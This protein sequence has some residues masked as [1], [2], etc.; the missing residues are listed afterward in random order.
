[1]QVLRAPQSV[2]QGF[3]WCR[4]VLNFEVGFFFESRIRAWSD[5]F[6]LLSWKK[7]RVCLMFWASSSM[8]A[9]R[10]GGIPPLGLSTS[11]V[12]GLLQTAFECS[13]LHDV[14]MK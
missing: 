13:F 6:A 1:M 5:S 12:P 3:W 14:H 4:C 7:V 10:S 2:S 9:P 11:C 8:P